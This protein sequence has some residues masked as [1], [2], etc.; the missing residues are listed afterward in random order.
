MSEDTKIPN[1]E[2]QIKL[3]PLINAFLINLRSDFLRK[4][5]ETLDTVGI[6]SAIKN[7]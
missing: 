3:T 4:E 6:K 7:S 2:K 5:A 1:I